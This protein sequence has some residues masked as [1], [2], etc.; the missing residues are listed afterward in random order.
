[1]SA[2]ENTADW[3]PGDSVPL[4]VCDTRESLPN[5]FDGPLTIWGLVDR[6]GIVFVFGSK[7]GRSD[8]LERWEREM[9]Q[10]APYRVFT[11]VEQ[12]PET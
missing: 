8:M 2:R 10:F 5:W 4:A 9:K 12:P 6:H 3:K 1:M 11:L 7:R